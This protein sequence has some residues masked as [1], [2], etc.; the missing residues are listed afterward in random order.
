MMLNL[1]TGIRKMWLEGQMVAEDEA[2]PGAPEPTWFAQML[3]RVCLSFYQLP[4]ILQ[5][6]GLWNPFQRSWVSGRTRC[7]QALQRVLVLS[8]G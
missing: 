2:V 1:G 6:R 8:A 7:P 5:M 3:G 4:S